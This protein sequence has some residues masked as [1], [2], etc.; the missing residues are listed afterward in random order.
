MRVEDEQCP[1]AILAGKKKKE[2][3]ERIRGEREKKEKGKGK[4]RKKK[5]EIRFFLNWEGA[6]HPFPL[7]LFENPVRYH[8]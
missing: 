5:M 2:R 3:G 7:H 1:W 4:K 8:I 6:H